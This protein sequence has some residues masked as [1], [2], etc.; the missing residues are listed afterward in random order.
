MFP[1]LWKSST[2]AGSCAVL[3]D[4]GLV[5][6]SPSLRSLPSDSEGAEAAEDAQ[7]LCAV[8]TRAPSLLLGGTVNIRIRPFGFDGLPAFF[9]GHINYPLPRCQGTLTP[10]FGND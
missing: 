5:S 3:A 4:V 8:R 1:C 9:G 10:M 7:C 2:Y 6:D